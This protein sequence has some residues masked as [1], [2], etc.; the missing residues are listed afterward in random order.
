M[1]F[2][3]SI[4]AVVTPFDK[5]SNVDYD[6]LAKHIDFL[7]DNG[8]HGLV[9][10]GTTGESPT[11]SHEEH[12][13]VTKFIIEKSSGRVPVMAGCGSNSTKESV[14][15]TKHAYS[16]GASGNLLVTPYY[17]KPTEEGLYY[18]F[19]TIA[20]SC[21]ELPTYLYN[22]PG[23][24]I[25]K[26]SENLVFKLSKVKNIVGVKDATADLVTP[27]AISKICG[28]SFI[29]LSGEDATFLAFLVSGGQGCISVTANVAP[30]LCSELYENWV[31]GNIKKCMEINELLYPLSRTLF[32]ETS[33]C[34]VKYA[35]SKMNICENILRLPLVSINNDTKLQIDKIL[36]EM[37]LIN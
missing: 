34:P 27:L 6:S 32:L 13:L 1:I 19:K 17:N 2:K 36:K 24:S 18:H 25:I 35:L 16:A 5:K 4:P 10:C 23:R 33:P 22:I 30:K 11:L 37:K 8:S 3:G 9:S 29:Q 7:I 31:S 15:L 26:L 28:S 20:D 12:K 21:P 14:E